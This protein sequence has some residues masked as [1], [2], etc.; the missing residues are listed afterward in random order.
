MNRALLHPSSIPLT[1]NNNKS[2]EM[3]QG[4]GERRG[5]GS[6]ELVGPGTVLDVRVRLTH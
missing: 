6:R 2:S 3:I 4:G 5:D 1:I